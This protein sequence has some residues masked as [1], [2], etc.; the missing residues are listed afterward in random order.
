MEETI[1]ANTLDY[2]LCNFE[3]SLSVDIT[4]APATRLRSLPFTIA[5]YQ[6]Y[7]PTISATEEAAAFLF[8]GVANERD[9]VGFDVFEA[10]PSAKDIE[11]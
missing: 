9:F 3:F 2:E 10:Y 6:G 7:I 8:S 5:N 1:R 4:K 11:M